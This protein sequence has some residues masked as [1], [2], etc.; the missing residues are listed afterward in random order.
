MAAEIAFGVLCR[1]RTAVLVDR[2]RDGA[3]QRPDERMIELDAAVEHADLDPLA[4][5]AAE[6]P[7]AIDPLRERVVDR[8]A[9]RGELGQ[10]PRGELLVVRCR[11]VRNDCRAHVQ[12]C[13]QFFCAQAEMC[14]LAVVTSAWLIDVESFCSFVNV[15]AS[16]TEPGLKWMSFSADAYLPNA[17][18]STSKSGRMSDGVLS[19]KSFRSFARASKS[20]SPTPVIALLKLAERS[21]SCLQLPAV[22]I[23]EQPG[24]A[25]GRGRRLGG[26][27][28][29]PWSSRRSSSSRRRPWSSAPPGWSSS[30]CCRN[31]WWRRRV[32]APPPRARVTLTCPSFPS[33]PRSVRRRRSYDGV[34]SCAAADAESAAARARVTRASSAPTARFTSTSRTAACAAAAASTAATAASGRASSAPVSASTAASA[35]TSAHASAISSGIAEARSSARPELEVAPFVAAARRRRRAQ[36]GRP[37]T[38]RRRT[39]RDR[40]GASRERPPALRVP[41]RP[42]SG[43]P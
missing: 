2:D 11:S 30:S 16:G 28:R 14:V 9:V 43:R 32:P 31:L 7:V 36:P 21:D 4:G 39:A 34:K 5:R 15:A 13:E 37:R 23:D 6:R 25:G 17:A 12:L 1:D 42:R 35:A 10:R 38:L 20:F 26:R 22:A 19:A 24:G 33:S 8:D 40:R 29:F 27:R 18:A 3:R 41:L